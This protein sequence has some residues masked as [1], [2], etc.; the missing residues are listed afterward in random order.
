MPDSRTLTAMAAYVPLDV[1]TLKPDA[2]PF[3]IQR[4]DEHTEK[5]PALQHW[6]AGFT[7]QDVLMAAGS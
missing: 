1:F 6:K 5:K 3:L 2:V 7:L 4:H